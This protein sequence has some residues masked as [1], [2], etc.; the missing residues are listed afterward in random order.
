MSNSHMGLV[1]SV[2]NSTGLEQLGGALHRAKLTLRITCT[3]SFNPQSRP[4]LPQKKV[5]L[6]GVGHVPAVSHVETVG[7]AGREPG[8]MPL[9]LSDD[10]AR[11]RGHV[12]GFGCQRG[13]S[14][15][16]PGARGELFTSARETRVLGS[17]A[18]SPTGEHRADGGS[19]C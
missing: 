2:L 1:A 17:T 14:A 19:N 9:P 12:E 16:V 8:V 3:I 10:A 11:G 13:S 4:V 6:R 18:L 7:M 5:R 15:A